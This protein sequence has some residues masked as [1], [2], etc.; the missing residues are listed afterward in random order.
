M[1][2]VEQVRVLVRSVY[3]GPRHKSIGWRDPGEVI[4]VPVGPYADTLVSNGFVTRELVPP[5]VAVEQPVQRVVIVEP[6]TVLDEKVALHN[7]TPGAK[8]AADKRGIDLAD[9]VGSGRDGRVFK[10]DVLLHEAKSE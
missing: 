3:N 4:E 2:A 8:L 5:M 7:A 10:S 1:A 6:E 9:V